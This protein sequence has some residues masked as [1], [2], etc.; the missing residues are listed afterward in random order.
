METD[1]ELEDLPISKR[2]AFKAYVAIQE[3]CE[4]AGQTALEAYTTIMATLTVMT[5]VVIETMDDDHKDLG[6]A[7]ELVDFMKSR[8][9]DSLS[10]VGFK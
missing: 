4:A 1:K 8:I 9:L 3:E 5:C 10:D 7:Q 2:A 6:R